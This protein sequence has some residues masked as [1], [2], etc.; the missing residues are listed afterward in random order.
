MN[1][2]K[3]A[4]ENRR[5]EQVEYMPTDEIHPQIVSNEYAEESIGYTFDTELDEYGE[6]RCEITDRLHSE[7]AVVAIVE[8]CVS[9]P[10]AVKVSIGRKLDK[11]LE[12]LL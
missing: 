4:L 8:D 2:V 7:K 9:I 5:S 1:P 10:Y 11:L 6:V 12:V 3:K